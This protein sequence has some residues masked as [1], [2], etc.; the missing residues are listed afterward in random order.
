MRKC[1]KC[2]IE[3]PLEDFYKQPSC[4]DGRRPECKACA[5]GV[6]RARRAANVEA[7]RE[8]DRQLYAANPVPKKTRAKAYYHANRAVQMEKRREHYAANREVY[9]AYSAKR[10]AMLRQ[11]EHQ[12]Y[13]RSEIYQRDGGACMMCD[14]PLPADAFESGSSPPQRCCG[15]G[16]RPGRGTRGLP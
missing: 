3:K 16:V 10:K 7:A 8:R 14:T 9:A 2:G 6:V 13:T 5:S 1:K 11:V 4:R 15:A 12:P